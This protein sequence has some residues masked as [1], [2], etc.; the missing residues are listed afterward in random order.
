MISLRQ[1]IYQEKMDFT[2]M[3]RGLRASRAGSIRRS[4]SISLVVLDPRH[5]TGCTYGQTHN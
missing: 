2:Y 4:T 1:R 5:S 3:G